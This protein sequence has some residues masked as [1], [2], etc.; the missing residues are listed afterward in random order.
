MNTFRREKLRK[1]LSGLGSYVLA[2]LKWTAAGCGIGGICGLLGAGFHMA[3]DWATQFRMEHGVII[4]FLPA[5]GLLTLLLYRLCKVS[6]GAGTNLIIQSV[7]TN[8]HIPVLLAPLIVAGTFLSHLFGASVGR[9]GAALQLGGS[10]GHNLAELLRFDEDDVRTVSMCGMA[11]CFAAMFGTPLT[12][13]VFVLEVVTVGSLHYGAFL[14]CV[15]ASYTAAAVSGALGIPPMAYALA[16]QPAFQPG[17]VGQV[18]LLAALCSLVAIL[19]CVT[20]HQ[21]SRLAEKLIKNP[22]LRIGAGG[23]AMAVLVNT[24]GLSDYAGAGGHMI[25]RAVSGG[26]EPWAFLVK[27]LLTAL[28]VGSGFRGGEIVPTL[29]IGSAFGCAAGPLL[30]LDPGFGAAI[31][32]VCVF[33]GVVNCPIA[34]VFLAVE[35]FSTPD[36]GLFAIAIAIAFVLSGYFGLYSSQV[37]VFSKV[38]RRFRRPEKTRE[39]GEAEHE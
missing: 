25:Q 12:A 17:P 16:N 26:I 3:I 4:W 15:L 34:T 38:K 23:L 24:L 9:E 13:A 20:L 35:M 2:A 1:A 14:P 27:L 11:A 32:M 7:T 22:Y 6:F 18:A 30:G 36:I 33:C 10:V 8:E 39:T 29:F 28:C 5:A 31:G 37:I 21:A 19:L